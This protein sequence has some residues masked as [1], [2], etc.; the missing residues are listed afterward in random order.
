MSWV[1]ET[2]RH[3][4]F[5]AA[6]LGDGGEPGP[7][8]D[9][10]RMPWWAYNGADGPRAVAVRSACG[11]GWRGGAVHPVDFGDD[12]AT[13]GYEAETGPY[14]DWERHVTAAEG[15]VPYDV[16]QLLGM[17]RRRVAE[18]AEQQPVA[19]LRVA[20]QVE[21]M[22]P[23]LG[24]SAAQAARRGLVSWEAI[25]RPF[26]LDAEAARARFA[27]IPGSADSLD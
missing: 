9:G 22:A 1:D 20:A 13:E 27:L 14:A 11:C 5:V 4:G 24:A 12:E 2:G 8:P 15:L 21:G 10:S 25:G 17:L 26:G 7:Q 19:A 18:L 6:V 3:E 16:E 23:M